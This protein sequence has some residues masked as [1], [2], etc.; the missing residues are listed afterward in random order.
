MRTAAHADAPQPVACV[1]FQF[2]IVQTMDLVCS[3]RM[4]LANT[5]TARRPAKPECLFD[6]LPCYKD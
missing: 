5:D 2:R 1:K 3:G 4:A 6:S